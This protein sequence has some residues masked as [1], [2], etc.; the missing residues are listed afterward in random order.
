MKFFFV[1]FVAVHLLMDLAMPSLPG[2]FRFNPEES[3]AGIRAPANSAQAVRREPRMDLLEESFQPAR[4]A[5]LPCIP[6]RS[7]KPSDLVVLLPRRNRSP[8]QS[9]HSSAGSAEDD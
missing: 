1:L 8:D 2:A 7:A 9:S 3:V 5:M 6:Q 4:L